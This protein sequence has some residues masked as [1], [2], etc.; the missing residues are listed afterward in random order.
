VKLDP[1]LKATAADLDRQ[2]ALMLDIHHAIDADHRA[3][4][5]LRDLHDQLEHLA[6][7]LGDAASTEDVVAQVRSLAAESDDIA[8]KLVEYRAKAPKWL[9]M[10]YPGQINMRLVSL[11]HSVARANAAPT[12]QQEA[13][14]AEL[15]Q[16]LQAQLARWTALRTHKIP[17][18][19]ASLEARGVRVISAED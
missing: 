18:L 16:Q 7:R 1:R 5:A 9:F 4:N 19:N 12:A 8:G 10:N 15:N 13:V 11:Q 17:A 6:E 14:Y 3:F 2:L